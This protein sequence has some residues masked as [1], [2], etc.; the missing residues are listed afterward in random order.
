MMPENTIVAVIGLGYVGLPLAVHLSRHFDVVGYDLKQV[1]IDELQ[2]GC[3]RTLEVADDVLKASAIR[4]TADP[5]D[6]AR[7]RLVI[8][9]VP[10]PIDDHK[11]PDLRPLLS[12][13]RTVWR[14]GVTRKRSMGVS[15][16]GRPSRVTASSGGRPACSRPPSTGGSAPS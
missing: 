13:S 6:L 15:P 9:A 11:K 10:T 14:P 1:R 16:M 7:C 5:E 3:D 2:A 4:F 12:A 8:V